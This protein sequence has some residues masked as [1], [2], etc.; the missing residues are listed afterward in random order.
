MGNNS[1]RLSTCPSG[2]WCIF[3]RIACAYLERL[4]SSTKS[5]AIKMPCLLLRLAML[6]KASWA[7]WGK[8]SWE[9]RIGKTG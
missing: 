2:F 5:K 9:M 7:S 8:F 6:R 3:L 4:G 1:A